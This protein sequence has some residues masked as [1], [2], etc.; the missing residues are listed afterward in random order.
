MTE[1]LLLPAVPSSVARARHW[2]I[3][4]ARRAH[5]GPAAERTLELLTSELLTNAIVHTG[6]HAPVTLIADLRADA[7]RV[8]VTDTDTTLPVVRP[9]SPGRPGGNGMRI[10]DALA[11]NWGVDLH[12]AV[13]KTVWFEAAVAGRVGA[14]VGA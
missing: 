12:P 13:G 8:S 2:V 5:T 1:R 7:V 6:A 11:S 14:L 3:T 4:L 9:T 10:V